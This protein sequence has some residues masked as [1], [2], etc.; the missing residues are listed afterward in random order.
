MF[1]S[2]ISSD[3]VLHQPR[4]DQDAWA[5]IR[6][7]NDLWFRTADALRRAR[8]NDWHLRLDT[9]LLLFRW[10]AA[11]TVAAAALIADDETLLAL[12][13]VPEN[14]RAAARR[15]SD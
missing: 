15:F 2:H 3:A 5:G 1:L 7:P 13:G 9:S 8:P 14:V 6:F 11:N 4:F 12:P 10:E